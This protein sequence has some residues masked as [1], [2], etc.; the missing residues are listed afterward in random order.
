MTIKRDLE[1][2][3]TLGYIGDLTDMMYFDFQDELD[4]NYGTDELEVCNLVQDS[5]VRQ[6]IEI[7]YL[8]TGSDDDGNKDEKR[9]YNA[10]DLLFDH[11]DN[12]YC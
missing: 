7:M 12:K 6:Y 3:R 8:C 1:I 2:Q 5:K 9:F 4:D 11:I 10:W